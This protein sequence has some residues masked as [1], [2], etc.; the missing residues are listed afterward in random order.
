MTYL[1][2]GPYSWGTGSTRHAAIGNMIV[3]VPSHMLDK[4]EFDLFDGEEMA[5]D[6][7]GTVTG[8]SG[9]KLD[10]DRDDELGECGSRALGVAYR[11]AKALGM[12]DL[13]RRISAIEDELDER[14]IALMAKGGE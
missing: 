10:I 8:K 6:G 12:D 11:T 14:M 7:M 13:A 1:A 5:I 4:L 3:N 2:R 9:E